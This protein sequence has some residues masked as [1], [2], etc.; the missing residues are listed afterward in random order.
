MQSI[1]DVMLRFLYLLQITDQIPLEK[2]VIETGVKWPV[3]LYRRKTPFDI[4]KAYEESSKKTFEVNQNN[5]FHF[6]SSSF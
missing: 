1:L 3:K 5:S 6:I 2:Q 4:M